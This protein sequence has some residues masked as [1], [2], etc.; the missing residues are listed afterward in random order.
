MGLAQLGR[1]LR[2]YEQGERIVHQGDE[3]TE[4]FILVEGVVG[5][6]RDDARVAK[7]CEPGSYL[8]EMAAILERPRTATMR[9]E[10]PVQCYALPIGGFEKLIASNPDI[11]T[12]LV[13][14]LAT[15]LDRLM[16]KLGSFE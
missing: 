5:V 15:R 14:S 8:G 7:V 1:F 10:T 4:F 3:A 12:K 11:A 6:Y 9:C 13:V 2:S 16:G